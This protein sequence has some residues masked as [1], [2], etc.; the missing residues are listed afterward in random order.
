[1]K[2]TLTA[3]ALAATI[4]TP[5]GH[6][7]QD[8]PTAHEQKALEIYRTSIA[9]RTA[10]GFGNV[11]KL[12]NYLA[13]QFR[14][15]G[16]DDADIHI[17]EMGETA[18]LIV[19]YRGDGSSGK[20]PILLSAHMDVVDA[21]PEDWER[22]PFTLI[23]EDGYFFGR[24]TVDNKMGTTSLTSAFLRLKAEG[25]VPT[26]D[27]IIAFSGDEE[28]GMVTTEALANDFRDLTDAEFVLIADAGGGALADDGS[29]ISFNMQAAEKT[30]VTFELT[31]TNPGGHSSRP[32]EDN[33]IY[34]LADALKKIQAYKFPVSYS[35]LTRAFFKA[36]SKRS[37]GDLGKA[38]AAFAENP[39]D[40][41]A[42][43]TL[44][45]YPE[46]VGTTGTTCVATMLRGGHAENALPQS[47]TATVNCRV[48][49]GTGVDNTLSMLKEVVAN[50][51]IEWEVIYE[52][53][54]SPAS[55]LREDVLGPLTK[56]VHT[57]HPG[58]EIVPY[59]ES[60]GTDG[61]HFRAAGMDSYGVSG[62][63]MKGSDM[64]AHGLNE[65][66]PVKAFYESLEHWH[67][68]LTEIAGK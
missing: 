12:A 35:D 11:P 24:G 55:P 52:P 6:A 17:K 61:M 48:F 9:M 49:P 47:A 65:R 44:R 59:M 14:A 38:M 34:D 4:L 64:Y 10:E 27:L 21:R 60:G 15:G 22:D 54:E 39:N 43:K 51:A 36:S 33:A 68:L 7:S 3:F 1:M 67:I 30:Y 2:K 41:W 8:N 63:Y 28:S 62:I 16:F 42:L 23:E 50:P 32:R 19:R 45:S 18:A 31:A 53:T 26:R 46:Y 13:D 56:A 58:V 29:V 40:E 25:F 37:E 20:K 57:L 66:V 5:Q